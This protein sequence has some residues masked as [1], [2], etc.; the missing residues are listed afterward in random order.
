MSITLTVTTAVITMLT[1]TATNAATTVI[2]TITT[3]S[4]TPTTSNMFYL[5]LAFLGLRMKMCL[6]DKILKLYEVL[7]I[8]TLNLKS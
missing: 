6:S 8:L 2:T 3:T 1:T 7:N 4:T 5:F